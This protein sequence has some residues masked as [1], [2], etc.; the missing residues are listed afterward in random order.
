[1]PVTFSRSLLAFLTV[2]APALACERTPSGRA[3]PVPALEARRPDAS[4][5]AAAA[6]EPAK[7]A[8][9][10]GFQCVRFLD[11]GKAPQGPLSIHFRPRG[12]TD[13]RLHI[14]FHCR[15]NCRPEDGPCDYE[16]DIRTEK[17]V[18]QGKNLPPIKIACTQSSVDGFAFDCGGSYVGTD[19]E[20]VVSARGVS[21]YVRLHMLPFFNESIPDQKHGFGTASCLPFVR[22]DKDDDG[23]PVKSL[24]NSYFQFK[25][26]L[27][28]FD[29]ADGGSPDDAPA[30]PVRR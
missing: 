5:A 22:Y 3:V 28:R 27:C 4:A 23:R 9:L 21:R 13:F 24:I 16:A 25:P 18:L 26:E 10:R 12:A 29:D 14:E 2:L 19:V 15:F 8:P 30:P 6:P 1:M 7:P 17:G 20:T 11:A